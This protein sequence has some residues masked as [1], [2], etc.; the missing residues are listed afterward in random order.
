MRCGQGCRL[1]SEAP[2]N[3]HIGSTVVAQ[4]LADQAPASLRGSRLSRF[5]RDAFPEAV[6][7]QLHAPQCS[8]VFF[9]IAQDEKCPRSIKSPGASSV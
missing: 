3:L 1:F 8:G 6:A 5:A 7:L 9:A 4:E 2:L